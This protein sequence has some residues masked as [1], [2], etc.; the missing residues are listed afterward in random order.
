M[1][2]NN[3][4]L[5]LGAG[6]F[7]FLLTIL[8]S[9][10]VF[11]FKNVKQSILD[12][13]LGLSAGIMLAASYFSLI[14]PALS[15]ASLLGMVNYVVVSLGI[16]GGGLFLMFTD[17]LFIKKNQTDKRLF[18]LVSSI[19]LHN[20]PEGL[21]IGVAFGALT[22]GL[23]GSTMAGAISLTLGIGIQNF[24]EGS[25]VS[26]PLR[27][28]GYSRWKSFLVGAL[29]GLVEPISAVIGALLVMKV[30][31]ILPF[32][33]SFAAGAMLYVTILELIPVSLSNKNKSFIAFITLLGFIIM[34][35]FDVSLG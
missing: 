31:Y 32:L 18:M 6:T 5:S 20:I 30:Q 19:T 7:T 9:S 26:L 13:L 10:I 24:P 2:Y 8:G 22:Y 35:I 21:S 29:S 4:L 25:A 11:F 16:L 15:Q 23:T 1:N 17:K 28:E 14:S 12:N 33:L 27:R 3:V 34:M